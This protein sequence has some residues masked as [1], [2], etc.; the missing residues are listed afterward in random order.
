MIVTELER[1]QD[2]IKVVRVR[3]EDVS[4]KV[5]TK[6]TYPPWS[7]PFLVRRIKPYKLSWR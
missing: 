6:L 4:V 5:A 1:S 3:A 7:G 2:V